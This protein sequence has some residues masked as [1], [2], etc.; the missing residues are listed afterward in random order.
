MKAWKLVGYIFTCLGILSFFYGF[1]DGLMQTINPAAMFSGSADPSVD[2]FFS[3]FISVIAPWM[4]LS[5]VLFVVGG[6]GLIVGRDKKRIKPELFQDDVNFR[7]E[8]LE[9]TIDRRFREISKRL[10]AVEE[11]QKKS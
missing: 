7:F 5:T 11:E 6:V 8:T 1:F 4:I 10:D 2:S 3:Q 9:E